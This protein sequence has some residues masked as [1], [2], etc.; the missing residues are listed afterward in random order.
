MWLS[1]AS[2]CTTSSEC[3]AFNDS[4]SVRYAKYPEKKVLVISLKWKYTAVWSNLEWLAVLRS[5]FWSFQTQLS[6]PEIHPNKIG[7]SC[8]VFKY[9]TGSLSTWRFACRL[10]NSSTFCFDAIWALWFSFVNFNASCW[11]WSSAFSLEIS[12]KKETEHKLKLIIST[13]N[14]GQ[15]SHFQID[16]LPCSIQNWGSHMARE[17]ERII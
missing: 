4:N 9:L 8:D 7:V 6:Q 12:L 15:F 17:E 13:K 1:A 2:F 16:S 10:F 5:L 11:R 14:N 3:L